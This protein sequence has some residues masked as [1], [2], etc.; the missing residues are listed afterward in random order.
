MRCELIWAD[1]SGLKHSPFGK[2]LRASQQ[3]SPRRRRTRPT[4]APTPSLVHSSNTAS[5][6]PPDT[7]RARSRDYADRFVPSR[8]VGDMRT[9]Y[10]L[11]DDAGPSTPSKTR[12]IPSESDALKGGALVHLS[13]TYLT[14]FI[15][16]SQRYLHLY[17]PD[18]SHPAL[19]TPLPLSHTP[20]H[21]LDAL[22]T[23]K[24]DPTIQLCL[25]ILFQIYE[26]KHPS[27]RHSY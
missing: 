23:R 9:S 7:P 26:S 6:D 16:T 8:D 15:R 4:P 12:I 27:S 1:M 11:I 25:P 22:H 24:T 18:R 14:L 3:D 10:H 21:V 13:F 2:R 20:H 19:P 5:S 17:S